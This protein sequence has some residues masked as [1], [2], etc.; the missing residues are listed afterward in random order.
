MSGTV[1]QPEDPS[2]P[3]RLTVDALEVLDAAL[4]P[5]LHDMVVERYGPYV[6]V[7]DP[8]RD[9]VPVFTAFGKWVGE[10]ESPDAIGD[11]IDAYE[12]GGGR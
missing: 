7:F 4:L 8:D 11:L 6:V 2:E 3:A 12:K 9:A 10:A 1:V 5:V